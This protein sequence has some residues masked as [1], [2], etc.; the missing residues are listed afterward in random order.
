MEGEGGGGG[1]GIGKRS[2]D[3][4]F[5]LPFVKRERPERKPILVSF[6]QRSR[7]PF[8]IGCA[9]VAPPLFLGLRQYFGV[10][11]YC[12]FNRWCEV[13]CWNSRWSCMKPGLSRV[14]NLLASMKRQYAFH[15]FTGR[16]PSPFFPTPGPS[17]KA[18]NRICITHLSQLPKIPNGISVTTS[19]VSG[20]RATLKGL[21][22]FSGWVQRRGACCSAWAPASGER[23]AALASDVALFCSRAERQCAAQTCGVWTPAQ[24]GD[25][26]DSR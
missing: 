10:L 15:F 18:Q 9:C 21:F 22:S 13:S 11:A 8:L 6:T 26:V 20:D 17:G 25:P 14:G 23:A 24:N 4:E 16:T 5:D 12:V 1:G 7:S 3:R 2:N 19:T